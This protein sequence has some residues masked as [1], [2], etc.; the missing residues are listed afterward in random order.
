MLEVVHPRSF[1]L[2]HLFTVH[3]LT[4]AMFLTIFELT[5]EYTSIFVVLTTKAIHCPVFELAGVSFLELCK[6]VRSLAVENSLREFSI[7]IAAICP[8]V[9]SLSVLFAVGEL[10]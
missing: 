1:V 3:H 8:F 5:D 2:F 6:M 10:P 4:A 9:L 7:V